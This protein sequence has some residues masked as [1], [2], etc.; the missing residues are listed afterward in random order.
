M[1]FKTLFKITVFVVAVLAA[2]STVFAS[3]T[4]SDELSINDAIEQRRVHLKAISDEMKLLGGMAKTRVP[5]D[6]TRVTEA[7]ATVQ[8]L[9]SSLAMP[10]L[11]P[12]GSDEASTDHDGNR[13]KQAIWND[14]NGYLTG[15]SKLS[16]SASQLVASNDGGLEGLQ[17]ALQ[18]PMGQSCK[19][20]HSDYRTKG[21]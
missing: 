10:A 4:S 11:W 5:F 14:L 16:E 12:E 7:A 17:S 1:T 2:Q 15:F 19:A 13:A 8:E 6:Q 3:D 18:G 9:A 20:C 21:R